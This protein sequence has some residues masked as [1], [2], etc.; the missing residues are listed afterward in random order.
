[1]RE[2]DPVPAVPPGEVVVLQPY[3]SMFFASAPTFA[4]QLPVVDEQSRN[5]VV[6]LRLR[7]VDEIGLSSIDVL[8]SYLAELERHGS[9]L[10][11]VIP[12]KKMI[13]QL[14]AGGLYDRIG[15]QRVYQ[16]T[17]WQGET[18][19][20]ARDDALHWIGSQSGSAAGHAT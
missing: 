8:K 18:M 14:R 20:R 3:G 11:L 2:I 9:M 10:W 7:G 4:A 19:R 17:E 12:D 5:S 13:A 16:G 1:V 15:S 6:I